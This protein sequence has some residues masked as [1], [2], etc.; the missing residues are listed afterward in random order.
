VFASEIRF[1]INATYSLHLCLWLVISTVIWILLDLSW[2][3][4]GRDAKHC[5]LCCLG[6][7][8]QLVIMQLNFAQRYMG[9]EGTIWKAS[10]VWLPLFTLAMLV[11]ALMTY[12]GDVM[13]LKPYLTPPPDLELTELRS[14]DAT[15]GDTGHSSE[16]QFFP[17][18]ERAQGPLACEIR[19][20][21]TNRA[22][23]QHE[24]GALL[25]PFRDEEVSAPY[26]D[27]DLSWARD[28]D[29][30]RQYA[31]ADG[32]LFAIN[33]SQELEH[34]LDGEEPDDVIVKIPEHTHYWAATSDHTRRFF[35]CSWILKLGGTIQQVQFVDCDGPS[36]WW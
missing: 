8:Q 19:A 9:Y 20:R 3:I 12:Q 33:V 21:R 36:P 32:I 35:F 5:V 17:D 16:L 2:P 4:D 24:S 25:A 18:D 26:G 29:D 14:V 15:S 6:V 11:A 28:E 7:L 30:V 23:Q 13:Q 10:A 31:T 22:S 34:L 1:K 27:E